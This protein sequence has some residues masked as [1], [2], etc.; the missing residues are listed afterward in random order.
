MESQLLQKNISKKLYNLKKGSQK[1]LNIR[2]ELD[3]CSKVSLK[4]ET[5]AQWFD[6]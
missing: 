1:Q 3:D 6:L 4:K 2:I 5:A